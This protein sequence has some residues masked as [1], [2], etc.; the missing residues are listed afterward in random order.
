MTVLSKVLRTSGLEAL[1][2]V[3]LAASADEY[4]QVLTC[5]CLDITPQAVWAVATD[6]YCLAIRKIATLEEGEVETPTRIAVP[7]VALRKA[8]TAALASPKGAKG[9]GAATV[10]ARAVRF[11]SSA[12]EF[13]TSTGS[14][15]VKTFDSGLPYPDWCKLLQGPLKERQ[16]KKTTPSHFAIN[17][18]FLN[19]LA[20]S[21]GVT[22]GTGNGLAV[23][24]GPTNLSPI[25]VGTVAGDGFGL[26][27][28]L[29][30][31]WSEPK[32]AE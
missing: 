4:R 19:R 11:E 13:E 2:D 7:A 8:A 16:G 31:N 27:M 32:T 9:R 26:L 24:P 29:R 18:E 17:A 12:V 1:R 30:D 14:V 3:G 5:V 20:K 25:L 21:L 15:S 28:P 23:E 6:S 22:Y 10:L